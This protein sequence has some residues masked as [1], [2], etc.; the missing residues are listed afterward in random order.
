MIMD[1]DELLEQFKL[2]TSWRK[3]VAL[4][5]AVMLA[6]MIFLIVWAVFAF[7]IRT[8][9]ITAGVILGLCG[10]G[11]YLTVKILYNKVKKVFRDY[12]KAANMSEAEVR[13]LLDRHGIKEI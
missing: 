5:T 11:L 9:L 6:A 8:L 10:I 1:P 3:G 12:F 2:L 4:I 13:S 7:E